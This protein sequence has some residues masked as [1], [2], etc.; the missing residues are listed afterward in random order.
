[1][2]DTYA[3]FPLRCVYTYVCRCMC[4]CTCMW[5]VE[6]DI[7]HP[8]NCSHVYLFMHRVFHR[9]WSSSIWPDLL[10]TQGFICLFPPPQ[11]GNYKCVLP[12]LAFFCGFY[13]MELRS[14]CLCDKHLMTNPSPQ[15]PENP[16]IHSFTEQTLWFGGGGWYIMFAVVWVW[17]VPQRLL[18]WKQ[19]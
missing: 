18:L 15:S 14:V 16:L 8:F 10:I 19:I 4:V 11:R 7:S 2:Y 6:T 9:S 1:M 3:C 12:C 17:L 5:R 13:G